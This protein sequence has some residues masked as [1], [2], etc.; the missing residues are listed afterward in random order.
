M[1]PCERHVRQDH[2]R[3]RR[4]IRRDPSAKLDC[5][6]CGVHYPD[7]GRSLVR[8]IGPEKSGLEEQLLFIAAWTLWKPQED[9]DTAPQVRD[10]RTVGRGDA[11]WAAVDRL[12][13]NENTLSVPNQPTVVFGLMSAP[14]CPG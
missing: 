6:R 12:R 5:S 14:G 3:L 9:L 8:T 1:E 13:Y 11:E 2:L 4:R 10:A 7:G